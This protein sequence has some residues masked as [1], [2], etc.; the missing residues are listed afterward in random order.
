MKLDLRLNRLRTFR[1]K[2]RFLFAYNLQSGDAPGPA[3]AASRKVVMRGAFYGAYPAAKA[4]A[5]F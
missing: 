1:L 2:V 5:R 3:E 4:S